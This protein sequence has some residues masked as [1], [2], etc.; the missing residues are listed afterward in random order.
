[1]TSRQARSTDDVADL[2]PC[3][4]LGASRRYGRVHLPVATRCNVQCSYCDR[5]YDCVNESRPGVTSRVLRPDEVVEWVERALEQIPEIRIVGIAGPGEPLCN[6]ESFEAL[7]RIGEAHPSLRRCLSTNGLL[8]PEKL[9]LLAELGLA[10]LS[11]TVNAVDPA[12]GARIY[13]YVVHD[14]RRLEG[15]E[16]ASLL[17]ERQLAG[18]RGAIE[19]GIVVKVNSVLIPGVNDDHIV[20]IARE[21]ARLGAYAQNIIP[22]IPAGAADLRVPSPAETK[23]VR[24]ACAEI[25]SQ[26]THCR[27]CRADATGL[28][29]R[30]MSAELSTPCSS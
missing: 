5:R 18:I 19:R 12:V 13:R 17:L 25:I 2:H 24:A 14:G 15:T 21:A 8:L 1:V 23:A 30:D 20:E 27:R 3:F 6:D 10:S 28:L 22:V 26:I 11:I 16:G 9:E 29:H 4:T 7:R